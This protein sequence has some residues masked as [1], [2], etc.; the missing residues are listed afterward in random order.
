MKEIWYP[1]PFFDA[2]G[3]GGLV[4][5]LTGVD[6][7][8]GPLI[9]LIVFN[10]KKPELKRDLTIVVLLQLLALAYGIHVVFAARP[11]YAVYNVDRFDMVVASEIDPSELKKAKRPEFGSLPLWGPKFIAAKLPK[12]RTEYRDLLFSAVAGNADVYQ[13][14]RYYVPYID[15]M[16]SARD[17]AK[18]L[19]TLRKKSNA[20]ALI[21][22]FVAKKGRKESEL[23][24]V[25][26]RGRMKDSVVALDLKTG[27]IVG[28]LPIDPY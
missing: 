6:V 26:F 27:E 23:G 1:D 5:I 7:V 24:Y 16:T 25:P 20:D 14:P 21:E 2:I 11:V 22:E 28:F 18:P 9:T 19:S 3:A 13:L 4:L 8:M 10:R 12:D 15:M 17:Q